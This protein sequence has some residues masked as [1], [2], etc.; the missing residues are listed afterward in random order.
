MEL[1]GCKLH[2]VIPYLDI[3]SQIYCQ[4][5]CNLLRNKMR[6]VIVPTLMAFVHSGFG[7]HRRSLLH[8]TKLFVIKC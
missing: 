1:F 3:L 5:L 8:W 4:A 2:G 6:S 7:H